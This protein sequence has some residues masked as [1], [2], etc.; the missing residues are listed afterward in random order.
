MLGFTDNIEH[1][2]E[3]NTDFRRVLYTGQNIQLV[4][5]CLQAGEDIGEEIHDD[6]DQ[7][8]RFEAGVGEVWIDDVANAVKADDGVIVPAGAKHNVVNT[9][10]VPLKL[11]TI[12]GPPEHIDGT[13][14]ATKAQA[15]AE[16]EHFDGVTTE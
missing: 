9:G 1:L 12:Y 15:D 2:T 3:D 14:H 5:M 6:R 13:V 10:D 7:F 11:Y 16:H 8:F 4:L